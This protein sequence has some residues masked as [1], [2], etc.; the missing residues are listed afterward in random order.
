MTA[1]TWLVDVQGNHH[2]IVTEERIRRILCFSSRRPFIN[3]SCSMYRFAKSSSFSRPTRGARVAEIEGVLRARKCD[4]TAATHRI[5][6][7]AGRSE[8]SVRRREEAGRCDDRRAGFNCDCYCWRMMAVP[9]RQGQACKSK[10]MMEDVQPAH[11]SN[12]DCGP[13]SQ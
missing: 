11:C 7:L 10:W 5:I 4:G 2:C 12:D 6:A 1:A 8:R 3:P 13:C 9:A